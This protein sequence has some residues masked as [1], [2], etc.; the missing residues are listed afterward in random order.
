MNLSCLHEEWKVI[1]HHLGIIFEAA[2]YYP[3][4]PEIPYLCMSASL[5]LEVEE[6]M[7]SCEADQFGRNATRQ[8]IPVSANKRDVAHANQLNVCLI[9]QSYIDFSLPTRQ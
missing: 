1:K 6:A 3:V 4:F 5:C 9:P 7:S 8:F 2:V